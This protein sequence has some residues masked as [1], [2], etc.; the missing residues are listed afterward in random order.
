MLSHADMEAKSKGS[1]GAANAVPRRATA[2][3]H[4]SRAQDA[5]MARWYHV[6]AVQTSALHKSEMRGQPRMREIARRQPGGMFHLEAFF[7]VHD[8]HLGMRYLC[9]A[10][11]VGRPPQE[12]WSN[13]SRR[14]HLVRDV[15]GP[16]GGKDVVEHRL[17]VEFRHALV[18]QISIRDLLQ[19]LLTP[20]VEARTRRARG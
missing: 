2:A 10:V 4:W 14:Q 17:I 7:K 1:E 9:A 3:A 19:T 6:S 20:R 18:L 5:S 8:A 13:V 16:Q 12:V 11:D 15:L